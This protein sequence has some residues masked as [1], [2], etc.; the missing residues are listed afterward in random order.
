MSRL[1]IASSILA[2][3]CLVALFGCNKTDKPSETTTETTTHAAQ[4]AVPTATTPPTSEGA[5]ALPGRPV[6]TFTNVGLS[7]PESV[8]YDDRADVYLVSNVD[9]DPLA[10]DGK[11]FIARLSPD[12]KVENA[13]WIESGKQK[14][15]LN[16]PKGMALAGDRLYVADIDTV[17]IF[18]RKSGEPK[19]DVKI[20]GATFLNDMALAPDGRVLVSDTGTK[21]GKKGSEPSGSDAIYAIDKENK[22]VTVAK[23]KDLGNPNGLF[24][25]GDKTWVVSGAGE[26]YGLDAKG[27]KIDA[28]KLPKGSLDGIVALPSGELLV[29]SWDGKAIYRGKPDGDFKV[30]IEDVKSPADIGYDTKRGRVLVPLFN[31]NEVRVYEIR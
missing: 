15:T 5:G 2:P 10:A 29:S 11:A 28:K 12:G 9:G 21:A 18:D 26:L 14:V 6:V 22:A 24:V 13:K 27:K 8:L 1:S 20:P 7:T 30:V 31:E 3:A 17:R 19:A 16:A 4:P 23:S 25:T